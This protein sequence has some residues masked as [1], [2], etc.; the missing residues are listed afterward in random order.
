MTSSDRGLGHTEG[1]PTGS[2]PEQH[3]SRRSTWKRPFAPRR[4]GRPVPDQQLKPGMSSEPTSPL[5][6]SAGIIP[7]SVGSPSPVGSSGGFQTTNRCAAVGPGSADQP[8]P[9]PR[10]HV[11]AYDPAE[12]PAG[13]PRSY[14]EAA[15]YTQH[16]RRSPQVRNRAT[17]RSTRPRSSPVRSTPTSISSP[18]TRRTAVRSTARTPRAAPTRN[19]PWTRWCRGRAQKCTRPMRCPATRPRRSSESPRKWMPTSSSSGN[20]GMKGQGPIPGQRPERHRPP[21]ALRRADRQL[22]RSQASETRRHNQRSPAEAGP[23]TWC[24]DGGGGGI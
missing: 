2:A 18:P 7:A 20:K 17:G 22:R 5:P 23:L 9:N 15:M 21:S 19:E 14:V 13:S 4:A 24:F 10:Q 8:R 1:T 6:P 3:P 12:P 16:R 11:R